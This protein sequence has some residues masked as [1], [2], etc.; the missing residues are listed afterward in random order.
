[1]SGTEKYRAKFYEDKSMFVSVLPFAIMFGVTDKL[2]K[3]F[4]DMG[5]NPP[6]PSWYHG[7]GPFNAAVFATSM[8]D[9]SNSMGSAMASAPS[10]SGSGGSGFSG[11]GFGGGGGGSW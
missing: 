2:A 6:S 4:K 8:H 7:S 3:A 1:V 10:S 9:F 11:G 5:L